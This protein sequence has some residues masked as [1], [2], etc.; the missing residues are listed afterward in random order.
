MSAHLHER[1][2]LANEIAQ[3]QYQGIASI[4]RISLACC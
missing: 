1:R 3:Y 4:E 2:V